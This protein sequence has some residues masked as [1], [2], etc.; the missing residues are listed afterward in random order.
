MPAT[1]LSAAIEAAP[2]LFT[3][4]KT[5]TIEGIRVGYVKGKGKI[6][7]DNPATVC[8]LIRRHLP[9][10]ADALIITKESPSKPALAALTTC[11]IRKIGCRLED[12]GDTILIK[13]QDSAID[14]PST[15]R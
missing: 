5:L 12:T 13:P 10:Q 1:R 7:W 8:Q 9:D 15:P 3:K 4:P 2:H 6:E 14:P 11:Q